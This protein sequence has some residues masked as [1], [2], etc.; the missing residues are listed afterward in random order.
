MKLK[1]RA[2]KLLILGTV[3]SIFNGCASYFITPN[4]LR[5]QMQNA[6]LKEG[7]FFYTTNGLVLFRKIISNNIRTLIVTDLNGNEHKMNVGYRT[8]IC[9]TTK[10]GKKTSFYFDTMFIKDNAI[11]GQYSH[12]TPS[13]VKPIPFDE[14]V[15]IEIL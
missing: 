4:N 8:G 3:I 13:P 9:I 5:D 15:K 6:V 7:N 12:E 11:F 14:I 2:I 1:N 10:N